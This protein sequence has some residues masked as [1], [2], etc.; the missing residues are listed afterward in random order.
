MNDMTDCEQAIQSEWTRDVFDAAVRA[1]YISPPW[2]PSD[3][4]LEML[5]GY[6]V[7]GLT[8]EEGAQALFATRQ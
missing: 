1:G 6:Y 5:R 4:A 3:G 7:S 2:K 8:P